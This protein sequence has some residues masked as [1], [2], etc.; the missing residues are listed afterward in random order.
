MESSSDDLPLSK[1]SP[2][3]VQKGFQAVAGI[4]KSIKR[5]RDGSFLVECGKRA[6]AQNLLRTNRFMDR[7]VRVSIHKTLNSSRGVIRCRDLDDMSEVEIRD[8]LK[9]QGVVG[10]N[11]VTLK[12]EGKVIPTNTLFLTFGSLELPKEITAGYL[13]VK[14][15][16]FVPNPM[17]CLDT[18]ANVARLLQS[19]RVAEKISMKV[20]V[21]DPSWALIAMVPTL[22]RLKI[23]QSGRR[24]RRFNVSALRNAYPFRKPDSWLKPRCRL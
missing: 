8:E 3:A 5:L 22:H 17:R 20:N 13:K 23:A 9:D 11:R 21:R 18:R 4:L 12:K 2:F 24:R 7:P 14:V 15:A 16:L 6:Q 19:V 1:L 10:V